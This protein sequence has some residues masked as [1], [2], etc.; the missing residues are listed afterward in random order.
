MHTMA[1]IPKTGRGVVLKDGRQV[2]LREYPVE[3]PGPGEV[4]IK[5]ERTLI[6]AGT[7]LGWRDIAGDRE[8]TPGYSNVGTVIAVGPHREACAYKEGDRVVTLNRH[9]TYVKVRTDADRVTP[10]PDNV[11]ADDATFTVLGSVSIHGVNRANV[12]LGEHVMVTGMGV[13][14]QMAM[15]MIAHT[16]RESL[17]AVDMV[18]MRLRIAKET[19]ATHIVNLE[20]QDLAEAVKATTG[21]SGLDVTMESSGYPQAIVDAIDLSR[22]GGRVMVLGTPWH[23]K[24]EVDFM[25]LHEREITLV[26]CHQPKCPSHASPYYRWTKQHNRRQVLRMIGDGRLD[27]KR[28]TSHRVPFDRAEEAYNLLWGDKNSVLGVVLEYE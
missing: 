17:I 19:G 23:R 22:V 10:A 12:K 16:G 6:S 5:T 9:G 24:I 25:N 27:V 26:G 3:A 21:G 18:P 14:G 11:S 8:Y 1:T 7:E 13:V 15:Q 28:L 20:S 2:E 4:L